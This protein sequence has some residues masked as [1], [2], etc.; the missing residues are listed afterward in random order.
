MVFPQKKCLSILMS[1]PISK[2]I[3]E[4]PSTFE[5]RW[6]QENS[7]QMESTKAV[8]RS[9]VRFHLTMSNCPINDTGLLFQE[10]KG[11]PQYFTQVEAEILLFVLFVWFSEEKKHFCAYQ[12]CAHH[13]CHC[14]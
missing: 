11:I 1:S 9:Y 4:S 12:T 3:L 6:K 10:K 8:K 5:R 2:K 7:E 13:T 14:G